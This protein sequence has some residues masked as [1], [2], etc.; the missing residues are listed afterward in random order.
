MFGAI[1]KLCFTK[2]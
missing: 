1:D 2:N